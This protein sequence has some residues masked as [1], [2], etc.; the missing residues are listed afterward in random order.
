MFRIPK[1]LEGPEKKFVVLGDE[2]K[3]YALKGHEKSLRELKKHLCIYHPLKGGIMPRILRFVSLTLPYKIL[4]T[5]ADFIY[6]GENIR[7]FDFEKKQVT[8]VFKDTNTMK[9]HLTWSRRLEIPR[10]EIIDTDKKN[11]TVTTKYLDF[12]FLPIKGFV[13]QTRELYDIRRAVSGTKEMKVPVKRF[14]GQLTSQQRSLAEER[15]KS[16]G[17]ED[18]KIRL[19]RSHGNFHPAKLPRYAAR[20]HL[21]DFDAI[22]P[23]PAISDFVKFAFTPVHYSRGDAQ[24]GMRVFEDFLELEGTCASELVISLSML[25]P[26]DKKLQGYFERQNLFLDL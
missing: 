23:L 24:W 2:K 20:F 6:E 4:S 26:R 25:Y 10:P 14:L 3:L 11:R 18:K 1:T 16:R 22:K 5:S 7:F 9:N 17:I 19:V 21:F 12:E 13:G 8:T 15:M